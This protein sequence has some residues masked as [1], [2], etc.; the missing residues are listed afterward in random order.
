MPERDWDQHYSTEELPWDTGEPDPHLVELVEQ[1]VIQPGRALEVGCG[2]GTNSIW[3]SSHGFDV[4]GVDVSRLAIEK[5]EAKRR[6]AQASVRLSVLDFLHDEVPEKPFD[7]VFDRG[8]LHVFDEAGDRARFAERVASVLRPRGQWLCLAGS[9][10]GPHR[11]H[12]PPR[13][14]ARDLLSAVEPV[15]ELVRLRS[16]EFDA[17]LPS[18]A[19]AWMMLSRVRAVPAQPSTTFSQ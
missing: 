9:T 6:A 16:T 18:R 1:G 19:S 5:A 8:V 14:S 10:E 12:G 2:T 7:F 4:H 3:L 13:R 15:L 11:E 17:D